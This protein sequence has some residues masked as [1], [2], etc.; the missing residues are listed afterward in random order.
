MKIDKVEIYGFG[1]LKDVELTFNDG[2]NIVEG[3]NEAGKTT[4]MSFIRAVLFG[5]SRRGRGTEQ[6]YEPLDGGQLGGALHLTD[7]DGITYRVERVFRRRVKGDVTVY[8]PDGG[9]AGEEVLSRLIGQINEKVFKQIFAFGLSELQ[10]LENLREEEINHFIYTA[11]TGDGQVIQKAQKSLSDREQELFKKAGSKSIINMK[12]NEIRDIYQELQRLRQENAEYD[13]LIEELDRVNHELERLNRNVDEYQHQLVW[14]EKLLQQYDAFESYLEMEDRLQG[15]PVVDDFPENGVVRLDTLE[16]NIRDKTAELNDL[17]ERKD[18]LI[19]EMQSID[20]NDN[21]LDH[22]EEIEHLREDVNIYREYTEQAGRL[23]SD[24]RRLEQKLDDTIFRLGPSWNRDRIRDMDTSTAVRKKLDEFSRRLNQLREQKLTAENR[25]QT[26]QKEV[27]RATRLHQDW[28]QKEPSLPEW[29][30]DRDRIDD[31]AGKENQ[32]METIEQHQQGVDTSRSLLDQMK[33]IDLDIASIEDRVRSRTDLKQGLMQTTAASGEHPARRWGSIAVTF[34]FPILL[35]FILESWY[36]PLATFIVLVLINWNRIKGDNRDGA[37]LQLR[38]LDRL[39]KEEKDQLE[40]KQREKKQVQS[41]LEQ[42]FQQFQQ[43]PSSGYEQTWKQWSLQLEEWKEQYRDWKDWHKLKKEKWSVLKEAEENLLEA[44]REFDHIERTGEEVS[45]EWLEWLQQLR[46]IEEKEWISPELVQEMIRDIEGGRDIL[47]RLDDIKEE[48]DRRQQFITSFTGR[49]IDL[50]KQTGISIG[51]H[52]PEY[53][54]R[55]LYQML[56]DEKQKELRIKQHEEK[57]TEVEEQIGRT[58]HRIAAEIEER[59]QLLERGGAK[60]PEEFRR[61]AFYYEERRQLSG[62]RDEI[63]QSF[64]R[65]TGNDEEKLNQFLQSLH[66]SSRTTVEEQLGEL[67]RQLRD[68]KDQL[69]QL[70]EQ[71]VQ[72]KTRIDH[73]ASGETLSEFNYQYHRMAGELEEYAREWAVTVVT[74]HVMQKAMEVYERE[75]QPAV[76]KQASRYLQTITGGRY[77]RVLAPLNENKIEVERVDGRRLEPVYLS[78]GTVEQLY[79]AMRFAL[80]EEYGNHIILPMIL[81]DIFVNFDPVRTK[82][83]IRAVQEVASQR[84]VFFF[85]C[86]PH[87]SQLFTEEKVNYR[88]IYLEGPSAG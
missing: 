64:R 73:L 82:Q 30:C 3:M 1:H 61:R 29:I 65:L 60:D 11:G 57:S 24:Q 68:M 79:L 40:L 46:F 42:L 13:R 2:I 86:H 39:M 16:Q 76:L 17:K 77:I 41:R 54:I 66:S 58:E 43:N 28:L 23:Q 45:G 62:K 25:R 7:G 52:Q 87:I 55:H 88:K 35:F 5:F 81:D 51:E 71:R 36:I 9:S 44:N 75:K 31:E 83:A 78:R 27:E 63:L 56:E 80:V 32:Y 15:I 49:L 50:Q 20:C 47:R 34:L 6:R 70:R 19:Q 12:L 53:Q 10:E 14:Q 85:S 72:L 33:E 38:E 67:E 48:I 37:S 8:L 4:L 69:E 21:L 84:Q 18:R 74:Q 26:A 22:R 59:N